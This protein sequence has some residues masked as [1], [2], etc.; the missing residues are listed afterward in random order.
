MSLSTFCLSFSSFLFLQ[1]SCASHRSAQGQD[2]FTC[3]K[4]FW[5]HRAMK[6]DPTF[7]RF[8]HEH[9]QLEFWLDLMVIYY[10]VSLLTY[11]D[12]WF[13]HVFKYTFCI[14]SFWLS[15]T[16][17]YWDTLHVRHRHIV[18]LALCCSVLYTASTVQSQHSTEQHSASPR[19]GLWLTSPVRQ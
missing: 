6:S 9:W 11:T 7:S 1:R 4:C 5:A 16:R 19:Q 17:L 3:S 2:L 8:R 12:I 14:C 15:Q 10:T 18:C 13:I